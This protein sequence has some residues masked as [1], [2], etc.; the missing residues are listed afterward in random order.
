MFS[1]LTAL[2]RWP[3]SELR[4]S[5]CSD[6]I[7]LSKRLMLARMWSVVCPAER[8]WLGVVLTDERVIASG[9]DARLRWTSPR[10]CQSVSRAKNLSTRLSQSTGTQIAYKMQRRYLNTDRGW[11]DRQELRPEA[12]CRRISQHVRLV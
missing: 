5:V 2:A 12:H 4:R 9:N 7:R 1:S 11:H 3:E 8:F 10:N 6:Q